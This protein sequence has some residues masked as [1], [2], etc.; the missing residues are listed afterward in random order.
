MP[1][2][3]PQRGTYDAFYEDQENIEK[4]ASLLKQIASIYGYNP[5]S[6][7]VY[8]ATELFARSAGESSDIVTKEMFT[9]LDK[10]GRSITLRPEW[11][12]GVMRAIVTNKL[13]ATKDLPLKLSYYGPTFR[14]ERPQAGRYRQFNQMGVENVGVSSPYSDAETI[15]LGYNSLNMIGFSHVILKINSI[16]DEESRNAYKEALK[17]YFSSKIDTMCPDCQRR[18]K[19]NPLRILDCKDKDD[20]EIIKDAPKMGDFLNENSKKYFQEILTLLD[21]QGVEYEI[22]DSLVRGLDYYSHVVFEFHFISKEGT[23]LGAIGAGGHYDNLVEEVGGPKLSSVGFAF[24]I[25]RLN[26]LLKEI[27]PETY[28][29]CFLDVFVVWLGKDVESYAYDTLQNLRLNGFKAD[30]NFE[31]K[32]FKSQIKIALRKQAK[33][34]LI[35]GEDEVKNNAFGLKNLL[36]QEQITVTKDEL[37]TKLDE[38]CIEEE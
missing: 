2:Y 8:E 36:N 23:N 34:I 37:I 19:I 12:A 16:G 7:P 30:M 26:T 15:T 6:V 25:E 27:S 31:E 14:Y 21:N 9:F 20:Q 10:G 13:Y 1:I 28:S 24:G 18:Y 5:I 22:D 17:E 35:I 33:F 32:S 3:Q 38:L 29:K 11:T 4:I